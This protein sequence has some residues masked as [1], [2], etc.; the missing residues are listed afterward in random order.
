MHSDARLL[1]LLSHPCPGCIVHAGGD[2]APEPCTEKR[3]RRRRFGPL[4]VAVRVWQVWEEK[5]LASDG[6][7]SGEVYYHNV[8]TGESQ[9]DRPDD[10]DAKCGRPG[11][12]G[13]ALDFEDG[14]IRQMLRSLDLFGREVS[15][16]A[17]SHTWHTS[18]GVSPRGT[19]ASRHWRHLQSAVALFCCCVYWF[20][21]GCRIL[22][23]NRHGR[24]IW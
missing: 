3:S 23:A 15:S 11:Y 24:V 6:M 2:G 10:F 19:R 22:A 18:H 8:Q 13:L 12:E 5:E 21:T 17:T 16:R 4:C 7:G 20:M 1:G 14:D 9:Y